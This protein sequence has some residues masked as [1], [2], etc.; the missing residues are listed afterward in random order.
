VLR[1]DTELLLEEALDLFTEELLFAFGLLELFTE[2][3]L[4]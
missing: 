3:L 2:R 4:V 1:L